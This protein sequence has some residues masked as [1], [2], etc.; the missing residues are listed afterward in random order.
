MVIVVTAYQL[1]YTIS[2]VSIRIRT[3]LPTYCNAFVYTC[4]IDRY[5][6]IY[7]EKCRKKEKAIALSVQHYLF[8]NITYYVLRI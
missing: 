5:S 7:N 2:Y 3:I 1:T 8:Y 4:I 6:I